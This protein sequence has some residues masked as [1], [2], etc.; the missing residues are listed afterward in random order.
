VQY[1][2]TKETGWVQKPQQEY[3]QI[4]EVKK[5]NTK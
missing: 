2:W 1:R 4:E 5:E 3:W